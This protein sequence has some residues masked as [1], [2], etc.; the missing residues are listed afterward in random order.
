M[1]LAIDT[2]SAEFNDWSE[3]GCCSIYSISIL[4]QCIPFLVWNIQSNPMSSEAIIHD[5]SDG[6]S[7]KMD[8][9]SSF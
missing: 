9:M 8:F 6:H 2:V 4:S 7:S 1:T 5:E 3:L